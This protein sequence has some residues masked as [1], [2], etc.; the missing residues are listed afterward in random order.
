MGSRLGQTRATGL[1]G[2]SWYLDRSYSILRRK[3]NKLSAPLGQDTARRE[4]EQRVRSMDTGP[5]LHTALEERNFITVEQP[6]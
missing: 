4:K 1:V 6:M 5:A 2:L 3:A